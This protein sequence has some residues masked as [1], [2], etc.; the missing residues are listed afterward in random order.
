MEEQLAIQ[1]FYQVPYR[2]CFGCGP[3]NAQG[4]HIKSFVYGNLVVASFRPNEKLTGGLPAFAYGGM[5]AAIADCHGNAAAAWF[6]HQRQG[7]QLGQAPL[8]RTV[9]ANL[10]VNYKK[11]T[12]M[13]IDLHLEAKLLSIEGRKVKVAITI[14]ANNDCCC[15]AE[16]LAVAVKA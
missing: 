3:D 16:L 4:W 8:A 5:L 10:A 7:L 14:S 2:C 13:G 9:S 11:P 15:V 1:D 6:Y 12:P